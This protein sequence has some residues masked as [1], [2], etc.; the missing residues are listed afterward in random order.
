MKVVDSSTGALQ[1]QGEFAFNRQKLH[2][3]DS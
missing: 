3:G 1:E 2:E